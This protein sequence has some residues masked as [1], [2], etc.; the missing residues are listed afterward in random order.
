MCGLCTTTRGKHVTRKCVTPFLVLRRAPRHPPQPAEEIRQ[1]IEAETD[2]HLLK[3]GGNRVVS[4]EPIY[5]TVYSN[6]VPNLTLVDM[7]GACDCGP[8]ACACVVDVHACASGRLGGGGGR[9]GHKQ[10]LPPHPGGWWPHRGL[11]IALTYLPAFHVVCI[12]KRCCGMALRGCASP[13]HWR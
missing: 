6:N 7:P 3:V 10:V 4:P 9:R 12:Q 13:W 11:H 5:L 1:E 8:V 2:R